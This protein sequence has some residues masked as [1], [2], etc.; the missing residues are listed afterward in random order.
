MSLLLLPRER[1]VRAGLRRAARDQPSFALALLN[2]LELYLGLPH[3][4]FKSLSRG[5]IL[6]LLL[7]I[8]SMELGFCS[9]WSNVFHPLW[10]ATKPRPR[11]L[12]KT[13]QGLSFV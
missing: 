13:S 5:C 6:F 8:L 11:A 7:T 9:M 12:E 10:C 2:T 1:R 3:R 4:S